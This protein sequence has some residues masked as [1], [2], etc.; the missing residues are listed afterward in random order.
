MPIGVSVVGDC[1][2]EARALGEKVGHRVGRRAVGP[3]LPVVV[4]RNLEA[5]SCRPSCS[6]RQLDAVPFPDAAPV[7]DAGSTERVDSQLGR[8]LAMAARSRASGRS[9]TYGSRN[10]RGRQTLSWRA[11]DATRGIAGTP[12]NFK[13]FVGPSLDPTRDGR[14]GRS[15][16]GRIILEASVFGRV[17]RRSDHDAVGPSALFRLWTMIARDTEGVGVK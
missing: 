5:T 15:T 2:V 6:R 16:V 11:L 4:P 3:D 13:N 7:L 10:R 14:L 1:N 9:S 12:P 8:A 17:V